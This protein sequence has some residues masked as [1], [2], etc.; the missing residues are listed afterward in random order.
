MPSDAPRPFPRQVDFTRYTKE[1]WSFLLYIET[2][3]VD[4]GH[5]RPDHRRMNEADRD[6]ADRME[7][8]GLLEWGGTGINPDFRLTETGW[9]VVHALR[10]A[11]SERLVA[12]V[13]LD[14]AEFNTS[15][16]VPAAAAV[17]QQR[18]LAHV[19][20]VTGECRRLLDMPAAFGGAP[21]Y[22]EA[23]VLESAVRHL[24]MRAPAN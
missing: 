4:H 7:G 21:N 1:H 14:P 10:R 9:A 15:N 2:L 8:D 12:K 13:K 3:L 11:R 18:R 16:A 20:I 22:S 24:R 19:E 17:E 6:A 23:E 5:G